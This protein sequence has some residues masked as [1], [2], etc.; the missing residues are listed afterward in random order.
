MQWINWQMPADM[1][2]AGVIIGLMDPI[3][4]GFFFD[5]YILKLINFYCISVTLLKSISLS[6]KT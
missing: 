2:S 6:T 1:K 3:L 4:E 5:W